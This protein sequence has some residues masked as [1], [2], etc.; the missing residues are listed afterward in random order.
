[1]FLY[2]PSP[3][4]TRFLSWL[5]DNRGRFTLD[6]TLGKRTDTV[7]EFTF[8]GINPAISGALTTWEIEVWA[9][10][11]D[12]R[13]DILLNLEAEPKRVP[14][15]FVCDL[16]RPD[17]R[18]VFANRAAL[19]TDRLFDGLLVWVNDNLARA[20]W[21]ALYGSP[22]QANWPPPPPQASRPASSRR[23]QGWSSCC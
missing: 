16:C 17:E 15:G 2:A 3:N 6:I 13:W 10:L 5:E 18:Q 14:G 4:P 19:W 21:L 22:E 7:H 20:K 12:H 9:I 8:V 11:D 1:V 23:R